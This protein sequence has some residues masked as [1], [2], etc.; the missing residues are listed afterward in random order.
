MLFEEPLADGR[1]VGH[2]ADHTLVAAPAPTATPLANA[3]GRVRVEAVDP[4]TRIAS[5]V[6]SSRVSPR[7]SPSIAAAPSESPHGR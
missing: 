1:W 2:A 7:Q 6:D 5:S 4:R 3:I